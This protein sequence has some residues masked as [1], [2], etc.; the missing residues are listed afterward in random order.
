MKKQVI[1]IFALL[2]LLP[3]GVFAE[4]NEITVTIANYDVT[5][6]GQKL[7]IAE[8]QY[9]ILV[10]QEITYIPMTTD[11][12]KGTGLKLHFSSE[13][14]LKID[15]KNFKSSFK[16]GFL[17]SENVL[18]SIKKARIVTYPIELNGR[19][20]DNIHEEYPILS[21]KGIAYLPLTTYFAENE[22]NWK[23]TWDAV[24][25]LDIQVITPKVY[26]YIITKPEKKSLDA[27][28]LLDKGSVKLIV[29]RT[30]GQI[31]TGSGFYINPDGSIVTNFHVIEDAK[32]IKIIMDD[33]ALYEE[34][35]RVLG[36]SIK[37]DLAVIDTMQNDTFFYRLAGSESVSVDERVYTIGS[38]YGELNVVS[39]GNVT[40]S[41]MNYVITDAATFPGSSGGVLLNEYG[42]AIG[43]TTGVLL[44]KNNAYYAVPIMEVRLLDLDHNYMLKELFIDTKYT[45]W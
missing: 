21:Y 28:K 16:Q 29:T 38:P 1:I 7:N 19:L 26:E 10:Y 33:G 43:V 39:Q 27:I 44:S 36:Y 6:D 40:E 35:V 25:G 41:Y 14:G 2:L 3:L 45:W 17:D 37:K 42:E 23:L 5:I 20:I 24:K 9:P 12:L 18:G 32:A 13:E 34:D 15:R 4:N 8:S 30:S 31:V 11:I 22:L